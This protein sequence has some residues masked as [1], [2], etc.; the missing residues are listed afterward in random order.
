MVCVV[1][2]HPRLGERLCLRTV[3]G[4]YVVI[5]LVVVPLGIEWRI[6][7]TKINRLIAINFRRISRLSP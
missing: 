7:I 5:Y 1:V 3:L 4:A 6:N 2:P